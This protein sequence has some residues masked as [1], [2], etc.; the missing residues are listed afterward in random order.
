MHTLGVGTTR[1]MTSVFDGIFLASLRS[2]EYT[3]GEKLATWRGKAASG[4][5]TM[6]REMLA[7]DLAERVPEVRVPVYFLHGVHDATCAYAEG[8]AYFDKLRAPRK[9]FYS[10]TESAHSPVFEEVEKARRILR[11]DV[12]AGTT[13]LADAR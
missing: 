10:F 9:G 7:T 12:L 3:V 13:R 1:A 8:K 11:E 2:R 5:S 4:V 6:W